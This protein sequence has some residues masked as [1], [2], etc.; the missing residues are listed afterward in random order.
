MAKPISEVDICNL[1]LGY[2]NQ[3][4]V[5]NITVPDTKNEELCKRWYDASRRD[6]LRRHV[7]NFATKRIEL[8]RAG[9]PEYE[10]TDYY[11]LPNDFIR[12]IGLGASW[13]LYGIDDYSIEDNKILLNNSGNSLKIKYIYDN[14]NVATYDSLFIK[15]IAVVLASNLALAINGKQNLA[16]NLYNLSKEYL[17]GTKAVDGQEKKPV[18]INR[19]R[20]TRFKRSSF[21]SDHYGYC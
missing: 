9:T 8:P 21:Y 11:Y 19:S 13:E 3:E 4:A 15:V 6:A 17:A 1:A 14:L 12:F 5:S 18:K 10:Y 2:L 16:I 20:Y 7:W